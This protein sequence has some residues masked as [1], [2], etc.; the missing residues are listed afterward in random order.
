MVAHG[1]R[2]GLPVAADTA[3]SLLMVTREHQADRRYGLGKSLQPIVEGLR[4]AGWRVSY[5]CME[6]MPGR[7]RENLHRRVGRLQALPF[8]R[9]HPHRCNLVAAWGERLAMG[10]LAADVAYRRRCSH[11]HLHDPWIAAGFMCGRILKGLWSARWGVTEHGLGCYSRATHED[12][13]LQGERMQ[14]LLKWIEAM[15]L[16]RS[17]WVVCPTLA[18]MQQLGRDLNQVQLPDHWHVIPHPRPY[19]P[20]IARAEARAWLGL[21]PEATYV[22]GVGRLVPLKRFHLLVEACARLTEQFPRLNLLLL[23]DGDRDSL[24]NHAESLGFAKR[25]RLE[26]SDDITPWLRAADIYASTSASESFGLAN[27]EALAAGLP[28]ICTAAGGVVEVVGT[29]ALIIDNDCG[30]LQIRLCELLQQEDFRK[31]QSAEALAWAEK[32]PDASEVTEQYV[33]LYQKATD[34]A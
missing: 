18:A 32:W 9:K 19:V 17:D 26:V 29:G 5:L 11:V 28:A 3:C 31:K 15:V 16:R 30:A 2:H 23:G 13:L 27:L 34:K 1:G 7:Q 10:W 6:D 20:R 8:I 24:R 4:E 12:G 21:D 33:E 25:L 22:L 14:R